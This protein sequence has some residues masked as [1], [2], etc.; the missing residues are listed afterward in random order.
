MSDLYLTIKEHSEGMYKE[1]GSKFIAIAFPVFSEEEFKEKLRGIKKNYSTARHHCYAF[2]LGVDMKNY[3]YSDDGE[4]N[5]SAGK[6]IFGQIQSF[7][8]TN[9][10]IVVVRYFGG[11]K[12]GVGGLITAYK[13]AT[14][15]ALANSVIIKKTVD[16]IYNVEFDYSIMS[17]VMN[18]IKKHQL[19]IIHQQLEETGSIQLKIRESKATEI[20]E[21]LKKLKPIK[22]NFIKSV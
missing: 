17:D 1:K 2:R 13:E 12:L 9:V 15:D 18:F 11:T 22:V 4:P 16:S 8:L 19:T 5:N 20:I 6:P 7:Q 10:A 3:R 14:K 21:K